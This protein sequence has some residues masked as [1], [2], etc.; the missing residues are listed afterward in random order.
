MK[1]RAVYKCRLCGKEFSVLNSYFKDD[2]CA[3]KVIYLGRMCVQNE[4]NN[5]PY[6][7]HVCDNGDI[8]F[9]DLLG[10]RKVLE[11]ESDNK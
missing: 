10:A 4:G 9:A 1:Y 6:E 5:L 2:M 3:S 7:H 11:N 8:G